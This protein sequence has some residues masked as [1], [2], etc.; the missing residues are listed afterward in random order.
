MGSKV[1]I[2]GL[3]QKTL[4]LKPLRFSGFLSEIIHKKMPPLLIQAPQEGI[5]TTLP[6]TL[7]S[8]REAGR[9]SQNVIYENGYITTPE[10]FA[11]VDITTGLDKEYGSLTSN[12]SVL[13]I[14]PFKELDGFEHLIAVSYPKIY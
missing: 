10:G 12:S 14:F 9:R 1:G 4:P 7:I 11:A 2:L 6:D 3:L 5:N 13:N 8:L